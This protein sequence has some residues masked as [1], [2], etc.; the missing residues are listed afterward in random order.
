[1]QLDHAN[2]SKINK[3]KSVSCSLNIATTRDSYNAADF[4][5]LLLIY[6]Y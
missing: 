4:V 3:I 1:M 5:I 6:D 2:K